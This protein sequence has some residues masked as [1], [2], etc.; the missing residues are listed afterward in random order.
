[1]S[2]CA[3][4][5]MTLQVPDAGWWHQALMPGMRNAC[6]NAV[7][8]ISG[9]GIPEGRAAL[10]NFRWGLACN[11]GLTTR[12]KPLTGCQLPSGNPFDAMRHGKCARLERNSQFTGRTTKSFSMLASTQG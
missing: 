1:M 11:A 5:S 3:G 7:S 10:I 9:R 2:K 4:N 6:A 12:P 8:E